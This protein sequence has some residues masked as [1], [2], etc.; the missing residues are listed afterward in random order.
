MRVYTFFLAKKIIWF[1]LMAGTAN[2]SAFVVERRDPAFVFDQP[3]ISRQSGSLKAGKRDHLLPLQDF[4][5]WSA[6]RRCG[7]RRLVNSTESPAERC[8]HS[9]QLKLESSG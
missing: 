3:Q 2:R 5:I 8:D 4:Y 1:A 6:E 9:G 7:I